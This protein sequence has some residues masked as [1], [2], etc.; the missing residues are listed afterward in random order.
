[1][2]QA[3]LITIKNLMLLVCLIIITSCEQQFAKKVFDFLNPKMR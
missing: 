2:K 3:S 1:M